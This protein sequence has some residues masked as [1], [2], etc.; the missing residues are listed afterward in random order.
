MDT[1]CQWAAQGR[2]TSESEVSFNRQDWVRADSIPELELDWV[3]ASDNA[4]DF[5][6]FN[7]QALSQLVRRGIVTP[8]ARL[9]HRETDESLDVPAALDRAAESR[10]L[11]AAAARLLQTTQPQEGENTQSLVSHAVSMEPTDEENASPTLDTAASDT[12][13]S[14]LRR[15]LAAAQEERNRLQHRLQVEGEG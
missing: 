5:G 3:A 14:E 8:D 13:I 12:L 15:E 1:V 10:P 4:D 11:D 6:P 9:K 7:L 2:V